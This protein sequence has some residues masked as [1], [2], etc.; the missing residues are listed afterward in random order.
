MSECIE[1]RYPRT[2][3]TARAV[4]RGTNTDSRGADRLTGGSDIHASTW[5]CWSHK[6]WRPTT[7][8][9]RHL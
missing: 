4:W 2:E 6:M 9:K 8:L 3:R 5:L 1:R 7:E